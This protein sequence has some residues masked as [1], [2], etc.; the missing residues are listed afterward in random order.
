MGNR[1]F[2]NLINSLVEAPSDGL[3]QRL[4]DQVECDNPTD[5]DLAHLTIRLAESGE[6]LL[7]PNE[8]TTADIASTG[9]PSSLSTLLCPLY[10]RALGFFVPKLGIP[11]R[12][13]GGIDVLAQIPG[14]RTELTL[15]E[16]DSVLRES[17]YVHF[18]AS[19][20]FAPLDAALY[21]F[22]K[23]TKKMNVPK[24]AIASLLAKKI[25]AGVSLAGLDVRVAPH[26]NFGKDFTTATE[27]SNQFCRVASLLGCKAI[28]FLSDAR[29][30]YQPFIGR[31]EA[32][33]AITRILNASAD[34]WLSKHDD[35]C[36]AM[37]YEL[38]CLISRSNGIKRPSPD[39]LLSVFGEN[40]NRQG[41]SIESF[42]RYAKE[43]ESSHIFEIKA[44]LTGFLHINLALL[45]DLIV[46]YQTLLVTSERPFADPCGVILKSNHGTF[47]YKGDLIASVRC[48]DEFT[49][50][51]L[52][53]TATA[54]TIKA[55]PPKN[56]YFKE[57]N[58]EKG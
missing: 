14:Y 1:L 23:K 8:C 3:M 29:S 9:G 52:N 43:I 24:L 13:A 36:Y 42:I 26:G 16:A 55:E 46:N 19:S 32:L 2:K 51:M 18:I 12:P 10:L 54:L 37:V 57:L 49:E 31:G 5:E 56:I 47:L 38:A 11:G 4:I 7:P 39:V 34:A 17:G 30:P 21:S 50:D 40:L 48:I 33:V 6:T 58:C 20:S 22:R 25:A 45:R 53:K 44:P 28:C 41:S 27:Y 35:T 15:K